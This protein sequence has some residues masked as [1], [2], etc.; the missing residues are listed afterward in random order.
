MDRVQLIQWCKE[1]AWKLC[2]PARVWISGGFLFVL[3]CTECKHLKP[4]FEAPPRQKR[5]VTKVK[6]KTRAEWQEKKQG[7]LLVNMHSEN[8]KS[9]RK[10]KKE[11]FVSQKTCVKN[12]AFTKHEARTFVSGRKQQL[13]GQKRILV[14]F[15]S[16]Y[17]ADW[18]LHIT[19]FGSIKPPW[20]RSKYVL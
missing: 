8:R 1:K 12:S 2:Y 3:R 11:A 13:W 6:Q 5:R 18:T 17:F 10:K 9:V 7:L 14:T 19:V 4:F 15:S 16:S 20:L